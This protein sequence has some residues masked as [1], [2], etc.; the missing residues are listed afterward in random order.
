MNLSDDWVIRIKHPTQARPLLSLLNVKYLLVPP[1]YD[2]NDAI[3]YNVAG[4]SDFMVLENPDVWPRAFFSDKITIISS[5]ETFVEYLA[6]NGKQPFVALTK[7]ELVG[8]LG[9]QKLENADPTDVIP[10][11]NYQLLPNS[12]AFD[13]HAAAAG[14]VCLTEGQA[15]GF[16]ATAN[17]EAKPILTVNRAF[18]GI[19]L[20][21]P[22]DYHIQFIYRPPHWRSACALFWLSTTGVI[23]LVI[24]NLVAARRRRK[25]A[26]IR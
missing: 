14:V 21:Q 25:G 23:S 22:G 15:K 8:Q 24:I 17:G 11:A 18:K 20:D 10:A 2:L 3:G 5:N 16:T 13:V 19:Y 1:R 26:I 9:L 6:K 12:T 7:E 4:R